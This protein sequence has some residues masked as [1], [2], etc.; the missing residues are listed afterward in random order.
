MVEPGFLLSPHVRQWLNGVEPVWTLLASTSFNRLR[1]HSADLDGPLQLRSDLADEDCATSPAAKNTV[2]LL[3]HTLDNDGLRLTD[4]G[5]LTR[6][7]VAEM[8]SRIDWPIFDKDEMYRLNKVINEPDFWPLYVVR[9]IAQG[10]RLFRTSRGRLLATKLGRELVDP[11]KCGQLME[12]LFRYAFWRLDLSPFG[13]GLLGAWPQND[14]GVVLWS[15]SVGADDWQS[16]DIL[17]R[18]CTVPTVGVLEAAFDIPSLALE[19]RVMRPLV[20]FGLLEYRR[21][22]ISGSK[23]GRRH[24]YRK[25]PLFDRFIRWDVKIENATGSSH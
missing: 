19:A 4:T 24:F 1:Q 23:L 16:P 18:L 10:A 21:E 7:V 25:T 20:W 5:N 22:A 11:T 17:V 14:V 6:V 3:R 8:V 2:L 15:L 9:S 12:L 13:R